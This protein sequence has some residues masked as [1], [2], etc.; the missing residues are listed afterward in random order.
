MTLDLK[1]LTPAPWEANQDGYDGA[2][3]VVSSDRWTFIGVGHHPQSGRATDKDEH[4]AADAAF[5]AMARNAF[6]GDPE[7]LAWWEANRR[8]R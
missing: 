5:I 3:Q 8:R 7:A 6:D 1:K 4:E 2:W